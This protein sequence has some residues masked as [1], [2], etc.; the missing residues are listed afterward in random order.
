VDYLR[1]AKFDAETIQPRYI[2]VAAR[3]RAPYLISVAPDRKVKHGA[4][5]GLNV[6]PVETRH[7][8][9]GCQARAP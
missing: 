8:D 2:A 9:C 7:A 4:Q 6:L 1:E 3:H 5:R